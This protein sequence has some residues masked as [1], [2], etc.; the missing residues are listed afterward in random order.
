MADA[1][2]RGSNPNGRYAGTYPLHMAVE[3]V[4]CDM[5][6]FLLHWGADPTE[7]LDATGK[8]A[9]ALAQALAKKDKAKDRKRELMV[10]VLSDEKERGKVVE[11]LKVRMEEEHQRIQKA[12]REALPKLMFFT[13]FL[14]MLTVAALHVLIIYFPEYAERYLPPKMLS[15]IQL[16]SPVLEHPAHKAFRE[17]MEAQAYQQVSEAADIH[18]E[19]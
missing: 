10:K 1:L 3:D 14:M 2:Q 11:D 12:R 6:A 5:A 9:L 15:D 8:S 17:A 18:T 16:L 19:L 4:N 7:K 13:F